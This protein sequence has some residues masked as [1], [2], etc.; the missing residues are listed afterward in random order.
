MGTAAPGATVD[1]GAD[2][3]LIADGIAVRTVS[4]ED[5][6]FLRE[7]FVHP[8]VERWWPFHG[9]TALTELLAGADPDVHPLAI[10]VDAEVA[11]Y[12]QW[13]E[14]T[15]PEYFHAGIDIALHP[16]RF[17][18][19]IGPVVIGLLL[20]WLVTGRGHHRVVI[21]PAAHNERAVAAYAKVGFRQVGVM[22]RYWWDHV[23]RRWSDGLLMEWLAPERVRP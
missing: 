2:L 4:I 23:E 18:R 13:Y 17:G 9:D 20:D 19:G 12:V 15:D 22:R 7:V 5:L 6:P 11:G 8:E 3:R 16:D 14:E 1:T 10:E 21:D